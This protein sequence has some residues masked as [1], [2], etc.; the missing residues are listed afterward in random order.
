M[1]VD[2]SAAGT[3][4]DRRPGRMVK[5]VT[6]RLHPAEPVARAPQVRTA[7]RLAA[8]SRVS[9]VF[10]AE[11]SGQAWCLASVLLAEEDVGHHRA[12]FPA[13]RRRAGWVRAAPT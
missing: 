12:A 9:S 4:R 10:L 8:G 7:E 6:G 2:D 5:A 11:H 1:A 3:A 13:T